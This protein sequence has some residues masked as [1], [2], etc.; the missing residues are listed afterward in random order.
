MDEVRKAALIVGRQQAI[1][2][3]YSAL[4]RSDYDSL[5]AA[6]APEGVWHRQGRALRGPDEVL[7]AVRQRP[8]GRVTAHLVQNLVVD[9]MNEDEA[10][11][12]YLSLVYRHDGP[13]GADEPAP[14]SAPLSISAGNDRLR[15]A[16]GEWLVVERRSRRLFGG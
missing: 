9:L 7:A 5:A 8:P 15:R 2:R 13:A 12:R 6:M 1:L 4:D 3:F 16:N 11:A 14:L 10:T